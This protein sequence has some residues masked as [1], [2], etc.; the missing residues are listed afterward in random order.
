MT[1]AADGVAVNGDLYASDD[2]RHHLAPVYTRRAIETATGE[3]SKTDLTTND[4]KE[5]VESPNPKN[6]SWNP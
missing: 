2:Y 5:P 3:P 4:S 6:P 1:H